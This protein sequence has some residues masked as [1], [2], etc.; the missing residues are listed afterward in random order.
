MTHETVN[1]QMGILKRDCYIHDGKK[2]HGTKM[3][4]LYT[5][6]YIK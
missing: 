3:G 4:R 5:E 6:W 1:V 2:A